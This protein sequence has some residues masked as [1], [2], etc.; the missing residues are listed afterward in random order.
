LKLG[1]IGKMRNILIVEDNLQQREYFAKI[2]LEI[3]QNIKVKTAASAKE[4]FKIAKE[5]DIDAFFI[6]IRLVDDNGIKL[7]KKLRC[8]QKYKFTPMIFITALPTKEMEAFHDIHA[9]DYLIKPFKKSVLEQ[10]MRNIL[11]DYFESIDDQQEKYLILDFKGIKQKIS[12]SNICY[13]EYRYRKI[14]IVTQ[15]EEIIYKHI[16]IKKFITQLDRRFIQ[17]H[18][19]FVVNKEFVEKI[20]LRQKEIALL[21]RK[22]RIPIGTNYKKKIGEIFDGDI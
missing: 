13:I 2:A 4:A 18:Q 17:V 7:A 9:Y 19:S 11:I 12:L 8:F 15:Y 21:K 16:S 5:N 3:N 1:E 10:I 20:D 14:V 22:E 6:D